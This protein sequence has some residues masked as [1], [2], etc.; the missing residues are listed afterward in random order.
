MFAC[1]HS[2]SIADQS[3]IGEARRHALRVAEQGELPPTQCGEV[4]IVATE[5]ATNLARYAKGCELLV[6]PMSDQGGGVEI[7]SVDH[8]PGMSDVGRCL[9]DG[10]ST[11]GTPGNG[12]GA[13]RRMANE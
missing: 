2:I 7:I 5:L 12:L 13:V 8:G 6:R 4:A 1:H 10:Y 9:E 11:G 3:Q